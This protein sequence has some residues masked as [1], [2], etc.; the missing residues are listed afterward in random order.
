MSRKLCCLATLWMLLSGQFY[1]QETEVR[2]GAVADSVAQPENEIAVVV[3][4]YVA[5]FNDA[6][7]AKL[8]RHWT[9]AGVFVDAQSGETLKGREAIVESLRTTFAEQPNVKLACETQSLEFPTP[10]IAVEEGIATVT[11]P[12]NTTVRTR[13]QVVYIKSN[14]KWLIDRVTDN[15]SQLDGESETDPLS[16]L[17]WLTGRWVDQSDSSTV[18]ITCERTRGG[19]F[20]SRKYVVISGDAIETSG[21]ELIGWDANEKRIRSWL[22]DESGTIVQSTWSKDGDDWR[23]Q[24][25]GTLGGGGTGSSTTIVTPLAADSYRVEK[26]DRVIDGEIQPNMEPVTVVRQP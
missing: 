11:R 16:E 9:E 10:S 3:G 5:A 20:F 1:G 6:D 14:D 17:D 8:G 7:V 19:K 12:D 18:E 23:I 24:S 25:V 13:Y 22:F 15:V 21:I 2:Q 26:V 4:S